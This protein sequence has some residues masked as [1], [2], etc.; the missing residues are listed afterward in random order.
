MPLCDICENLDLKLEGGCDDQRQSLGG[1]DEILSRASGNP[2][3]PDQDGCD[4]CAF[5]CAVLQDSESWRE[6]QVELSGKLVF[7]DSSRLD[8]R[9]PERADGS[10]Y[11]AD[12]LVL[13]LYT[14]EF[15]E[16]YQQPAHGMEDDAEDT[17]DIESMDQ[18][19]NDT[20][21]DC[22]CIVPVDP[23]DDKCFDLLRSWI[24]ACSMHEQCAGMT[25]ALMP[26]RVIEIPDSTSE[27]PRLLVTN[28][29][30]EQYV[31]LSHCWGSADAA[32]KLKDSL[33]PDYQR[34]LDLAQLPQNVQDAVHITRRLGFQYLWVDALCIS[35]DNAQDWAE[36]KAKLPL[37]YGQAALMISASIAT[38][39]D[40]GILAERH[41][42]MS[43][44]MG[45]D[46]K[47]GL[48]Q[49]ILR[50]K[51]DIERS[52]LATR[53]WAAQERMLAPRI[54]HYTRRQMIWECATGLSFE[55]SGIDDGRFGRDPHDAFFSKPKLQP[56]L[57]AG[58]RGL[59]PGVPDALVVERRTTVVVVGGGGERGGER[60]LARRLY[61]WLQCVYEYAPRD[62]AVASDKLPALAGLAT[63]LNHDGAMGD[64]MAGIWSKDLAAGLA[65]SRPWR[66]LSSPP[67]YQA[68]S[69]SWAGV[70]GGVSHAVLGSTHEILQL[71]QP[72]PLP[73]PP[74]PALSNYYDE[75]ATVC[76]RW[77]AEFEPKLI[78]HHI[79]LD[80]P[81]QP[82]GAVREGSYLVVEGT[83]LGALELPKL[84]DALLDEGLPRVNNPVVV[85]DRSNAFDCPCC[86][87]HRPT[88]SSSSEEGQREDTRNEE[89]AHFDLCMVLLGDA[90]R[91][92]AGYVDLLALRWVD[93]AARTAARA[94]LVVF[95]MRKGRAEIELFRGAFRAVGMKRMT[96]NLV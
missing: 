7:L 2:E 1:Y 24:A 82:Y 21:I 68:P 58:L 87:R 30:S 10:S 11:V 70:N 8:V 85:L 33:I 16:N 95:H 84:R 86:C 52:H 43:P 15:I 50:W 6:R 62:L 23:R 79:V 75:E 89:E 38:D 36:E 29:E 37:Y 80:D 18:R 69:W 4:G 77:T 71:G 76:Y 56:L 22:K 54:V 47:F 32:S 20:R 17:D 83:C 3:G 34:G 41:V 19:N 9:S 88:P 66:L 57:E 94:G 74:P 90:R 14:D 25:P 26:K 93:R 5:F 55:A 53:G 42:P 81:S 45:K 49:R 92:P 51:D 28:G 48:R 44:I 67:A 72:P 39:A 96:L 73:P 59:H 40:S 61:A 13:D 64:Y 35:Q 78:D 12:D 91:R 60:E 27:R 46:R 63:I 65:W 31:V